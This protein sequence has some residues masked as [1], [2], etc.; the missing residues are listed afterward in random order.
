MTML[1]F[2]VWLYL[3]ALPQQPEQSVSHVHKDTQDVSKCTVFSFTQYICRVPCVKLWGEMRILGFS[4][5][6]LI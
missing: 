6:S 2:L 4:Q 3:M 5:E 1:L